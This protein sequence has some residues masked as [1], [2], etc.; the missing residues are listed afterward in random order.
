[1]LQR[2]AYRV[3]AGAATHISH[4]EW[5][6]SIVRREATSDQGAPQWLLGRGCHGCLKADFEPP[7]DFP[8]VVQLAR[9]PLTPPVWGECAAKVRT[10]SHILDLADADGCAG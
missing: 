9:R 5:P 6:L 8:Q 4:R 1:M 2:A 7:F 3:R 10:R